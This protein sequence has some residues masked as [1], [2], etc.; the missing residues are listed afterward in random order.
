MTPRTVARQAPLSVGI[1]QATILEWVA[2]SSSRGSSQPR[3]RTRVSCTTGGFFTSWA[4]REA[5]ISVL[6]SIRYLSS[7]LLSHQSSDYTTSALPGYLQRDVHYNNTYNHAKTTFTDLPKWSL[8]SNFYFI[9]HEWILQLSQLERLGPC[10]SFPLCQNKL[11]G[12]SVDLNL[13]PG[14]PLLIVWS[15]ISYLLSEPRFSSVK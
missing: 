14:L 7:T 15:W 1:L 11:M 3:N 5:P 9:W 13:T 12:Y 10:G 6:T 8:P 2:M 4:T